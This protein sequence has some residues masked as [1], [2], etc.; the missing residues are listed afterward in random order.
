MWSRRDFTNRVMFELGP[1]TN[2]MWV[3]IKREIYFKEFGKSSICRVG[4][5]VADSRKN[6]NSSP[7]SVCWQNSCLLMEVTLGFF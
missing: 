3:C 7:D 4:C 1:R 2:K 6:L 5:Q